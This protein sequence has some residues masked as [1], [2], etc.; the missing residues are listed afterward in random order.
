MSEINP[1]QCG[2][3]MRELTTHDASAVGVVSLS[4]R[5]GTKKPMKTRVSRGFWTTLGPTT[6]ERRRDGS[7]AK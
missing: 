5:G 3:G 1:Y 7:Y 2:V 6:T 4:I